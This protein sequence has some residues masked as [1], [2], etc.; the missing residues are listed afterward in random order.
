MI[1]SYSTIKQTPCAKCAKMTDTTAQ[2]PTIRHP[3][4]N[5]NNPG[6]TTYAFE[7]LHPGCI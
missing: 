1:T 3:K 2:L 4:A 6:E 7:P 5:T